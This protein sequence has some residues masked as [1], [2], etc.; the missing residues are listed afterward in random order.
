MCR[1]VDSIHLHR[2]SICGF[3]NTWLQPQELAF[4]GGKAGAVAAEAM[5]AGFLNLPNYFPSNQEVSEILFKLSER[6]SVLG[7]DQLKLFLSLPSSRV[8]ANLNPKEEVLAKENVSSSV[9]FCLHSHIKI[10][11]LALLTCSPHIARISWLQVSSKRMFNAGT[12][13]GIIS[14][15]T[16]NQSFYLKWME[17]FVFSLSPCGEI[18]YNCLIEKMKAIHL[19][20]PELLCAPVQTCQ[21]HFCC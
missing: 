8:K 15:H 3:T 9:N 16:E 5:S 12:S 10:N 14:I 1:A 11:F 19:M 18:S 13:Q 6:F 7:M 4:V 20:P 17:I 2:D 21:Y